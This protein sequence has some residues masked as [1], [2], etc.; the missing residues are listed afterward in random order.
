MFLASASVL[1]I[2]VFGSN[3]FD[4]EVVSGFSKC[5]GD[6]RFR[7]LLSHFR[8]LKIYRAWVF[9]QF[10]CLCELLLSHFVD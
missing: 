2:S 3:M 7:R 9:Q 10:L 4:K 8:Q 5:S 1:I 6:W